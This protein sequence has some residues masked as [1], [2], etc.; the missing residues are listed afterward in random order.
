[1][2][3][4]TRVVVIRCGVYLGALHLQTCPVLELQVISDG[5]AQLG[6]KGGLQ[7]LQP[8]SEPYPVHFG[9]HGGIVGCG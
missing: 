8:E 9:S 6:K 4:R 1:M 7:P 2:A 3:A 5:T